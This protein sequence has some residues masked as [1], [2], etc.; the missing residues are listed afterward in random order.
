MN[1]KIQWRTIVRYM[2][3]LAAIMLIV[4]GLS[5]GAWLYV[6]TS[7]VT[8]RPII[9][10]AQTQS[11]TPEPSSTYLTPSVTEYTPLPA[12]PAPTPTPTPTPTPVVPPPKPLCDGVTG[13]PQS[14]TIESLGIV[15]ASVEVIAVDPM[16]SGTIGDPKNKHAMGW[17]A[18]FPGVKP[19]ACKGTILFDGH[20][21]HD[22]SAI[23][24]ESY[25]GVPMSQTN[26][27]GMVVQVA[28]DKGVYWYRIDWQATVAAGQYPTFARNNDLYDIHQSQEEKIFFATCS[29][30]N[31]VIHTTETMFSGHRIPPPS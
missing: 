30:W 11:A 24:K 29:D 20:T 17:Q 31:G 26:K 21:Y 3:Q 18:K 4:A 19:G 12:E 14:V 16:K 13:T 10:A 25:G 22:N 27:I 6:K 5:L 9:E 8:D 7:V 1:R 15:G 2:T 23:F 28:T